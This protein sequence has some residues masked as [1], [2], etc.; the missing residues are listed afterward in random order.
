MQHLHFLPQKAFILRSKVNDGCENALGGKTESVIQMFEP[1]VTFT[2]LLVMLFSL[3]A[4]GLVLTSKQ[5]HKPLMNGD[6][7]LASEAKGGWRPVASANDKLWGWGQAPDP[8][9][10]LISSFVNE[11]SAGSSPR[12]CLALMALKWERTKWYCSFALISK[13]FLK[14][15]LHTHS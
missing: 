10:A 6:R 7:W 14:C 8:V 1:L 15:L 12:V 13:S 11:R 4:L 9:W 5:T 3:P 2:I